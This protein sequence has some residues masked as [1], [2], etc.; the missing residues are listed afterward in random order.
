MRTPKLLLR[1]ICL[2]SLVSTTGC[3]IV[4][5]A[6]LEGLEVD[7]TV[8]GGELP[9][10]ETCGG[11]GYTVVANGDYEVTTVGAA[12]DVSN[13]TCGATRAAPGP[14][15]FL[16]IEASQGQY[17][18]FHVSPATGETAVNVD[19]VVS[20]FRAGANGQCNTA[21]CTYVANRCSGKDEHFGV[22]I[23]SNPGGTWNLAIDNALGDGARFHVAVYRPIC[24][25][26]VLEHGE[27]CDPSVTQDPCGA[28]CRRIL[29][30]TG[31]AQEPNDDRFWADRVAISKGAP[32]IRIE[33]A[34]AGICDP[35]VLVVTVPANETLQVRA[36]AAGGAVCQ[37]FA[38]AT[39]DYQVRFTTATGTS[40][41]AFQ[42]LAGCGGANIAG[43]QSGTEVF[44]TV[45]G[46]T[47]TTDLRNYRL[48]FQIP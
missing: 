44:V 18:H 34:V 5:D 9:A 10:A 7:T 38:S 19:P 41:G 25:N 43:G 30:A 32:P 28:D 36:M 33:D 40:L 22:E 27:S 26:G 31:P 21:E 12:N 1:S 35:D 14:E 29:S 47:G 37:S 23:P 16:G 8:D 39:A 20:L 13:S 46:A 4:D 45:E 17:W 6:A 24:N 15:V 11:A 42:D 2:A 3:F 48:Q